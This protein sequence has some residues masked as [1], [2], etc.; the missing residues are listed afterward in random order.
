MYCGF[1]LDGFLSL[2]P[3]N[4]EYNDHLIVELFHKIFLH[5]K[6]HKKYNVN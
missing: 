2:F 1:D 3:E 6:K 5:E 4:C